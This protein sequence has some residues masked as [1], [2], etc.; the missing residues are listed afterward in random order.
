MSTQ[1]VIPS[2]LIPP[3]PRVQHLARQVHELGPGVL[4]YFFAELIAGSSSIQD[5]LEA[6]A[7]IAPCTDFI[8]ANTPERP[9]VWRIK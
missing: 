4:S 8:A 5:Q 7:R 1:T 9:T 6:F 2:S 3:P